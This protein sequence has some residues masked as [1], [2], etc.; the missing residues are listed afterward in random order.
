MRIPGRSEKFLDRGIAKKIACIYCLEI[1]LSASWQRGLLGPSFKVGT[2]YPTFLGRGGFP[3]HAHA[4]VGMAP[5]L[6]TRRGG[7]AYLRARL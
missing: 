3:Q 5:N 4:S 2:A 1:I 6:C 7:T